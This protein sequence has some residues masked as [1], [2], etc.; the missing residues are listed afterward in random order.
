M[1]IW[2][3]RFFGFWALAGSAIG[4]AAVFPALLRIAH[5]PLEQQIVTGVTTAFFGWGIWCGF[6]M[7]EGQPGAVKGNRN[8]WLLQVPVLHSP[9]A[10]WALFTGVEFE[11][12]ARFSPLRFGIDW[13]VLKSQFLVDIGTGRSAITLGLNVFALVAALYLATR[14][15]GKR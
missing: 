3:R 5:L 10:S 12:A 7:L 15:G 1:N 13:Q 14:S 11:V 2:L 4:L 8:F 6:A 9:W